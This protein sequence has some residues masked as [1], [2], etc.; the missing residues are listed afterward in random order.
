M[1]AMNLVYF[2]SIPCIPD[3][4]GF[5]DIPQSLREKGLVADEKRADVFSAHGCVSMES[6]SFR[7]PRQFVER[8]IIVKMA[9]TGF[10][11][12]ESLP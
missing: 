12:P 11:I 2:W 8:N 5:S 3:G 7:W 6:T 1:Y 10:E 9:Q 4:H